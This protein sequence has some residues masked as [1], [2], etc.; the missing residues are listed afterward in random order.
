MP[1]TRRYKN[2]KVQ[3]MSKKG[4]KGNKGNKTKRNIKKSNKSKNS[5]AKGST[6]Y[7][8]SKITY[9]E[10]SKE[11]KLRELQF[12]IESLRNELNEIKLALKNKKEFEK[13]F[14]DSVLF[15]SSEMEKNEKDI[16]NLEK[17]YKEKVK[18]LNSLI[19][20]YQIYNIL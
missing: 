11:D 2:K 7:L 17:E 5:K 19:G 13:E 6:S 3:K 9:F 20:A 12:K 15:D 8:D 4:N 16:K 14:T 10:Q 1:K 18:K